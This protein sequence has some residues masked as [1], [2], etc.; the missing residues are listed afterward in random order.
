MNGK[1]VFTYQ[2][3]DVDPKITVELSPDSDLD[4]VLEA[5]EQFLLG[6][7]FSFEGQLD[8]IKEGN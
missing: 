8:F 5:F 2:F 3:S 4:R 1:M 7:G 6:A